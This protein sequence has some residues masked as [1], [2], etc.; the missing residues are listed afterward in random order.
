MLTE[1]TGRRRYRVY[2]ATEL[3][4]LLEADPLAD[5]FPYEPDL[6]SGTP[7]GAEPG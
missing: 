5:D 1:I 4:H 7:P 2:T 6:P 3:L